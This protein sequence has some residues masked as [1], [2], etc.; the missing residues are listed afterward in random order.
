MEI[1]SALL[2]LTQEQNVFLLHSLAPAEH[3]CL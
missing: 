2:T 1:C 3:V